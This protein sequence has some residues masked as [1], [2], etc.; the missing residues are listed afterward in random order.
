MYTCVYR[1]FY[2]LLS[3]TKASNAFDMSDLGQNL[4][5]GNS[6]ESGGKKK[7][8]EEFLGANA[9]L[10]NLDNLITAPAPAPANT[11]GP[12]SGIFG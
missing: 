8:A 3:G 4:D 12:F 1:P 10:V 9:S 11:V 6:D 5:N 2:S 7:T